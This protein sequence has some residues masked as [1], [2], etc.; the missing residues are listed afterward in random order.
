MVVPLTRLDYRML[1]AETVQAV[2]DALYYMMLGEQREA[3]PPPLT[4]ET[5]PGFFLLRRRNAIVGH[6][7]LLAH[8]LA[9]YRAWTVEAS[10]ARLKYLQVDTRPQRLP[11]GEA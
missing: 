2:E 10:P 4:F 7:R 1:D 11:K 9:P 6:E 5:E 8:L 3:E